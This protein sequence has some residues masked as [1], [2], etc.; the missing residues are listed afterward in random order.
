MTYGRHHDGYCVTTVSASDDCLR[1]SLKGHSGA[2]WH[3]CLNDVDC[4]HGSE[5]RGGNG[6]ASANDSHGH[7]NGYV[8]NVVMKKADTHKGQATYMVVVVVAP[9]GKHAKEVHTKSKGAD[10]Q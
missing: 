1:G 3:A 8:P 4:G 9:H 5:N 2:S 7:G 10:Q 6:Y